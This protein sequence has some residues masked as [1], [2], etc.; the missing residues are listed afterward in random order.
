MIQTEW[1]SIS[2]SRDW[3]Y[4]VKA[5]DGLNALFGVDLLS[6]DYTIAIGNINGRYVNIIGEVSYYAIDFD[7]RTDTVSYID[8]QFKFVQ[9]KII[10]LSSDPLELEV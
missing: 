8:T 7:Q 5:S 10:Q 4:F 1:F 9:N 6:E 2:Q 3:I